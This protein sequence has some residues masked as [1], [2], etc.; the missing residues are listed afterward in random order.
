MRIKCIVSYDGT[1]YSGFQ[2]QPNAVSVQGE[3]EKVLSKMHSVERIQI[4]ASGRTDKGVHARGQVFHF[5]SDLPIQAYA[6]KRAINAQ[7]PKD[8]Y[9]KEVEIVP[10]D[11]HARYNVVAKQYSY[12]VNHDPDED[13]FMRNFEMHYTYRLDFTKMETAMKHFLGAHDFTT[14]C[15]AKNEKVN[16]VRTIYRFDMIRETENRTRF[17]V[18]GDGF[19]YNMVRIMVGTVLD[20]GRGRF[21]P[22]N[23]VHML[24]GKN[25][26]LAGK[27]AAAHGLYLDYVVYD[28]KEK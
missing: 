16:C 18:Y 24:E 15:S 9:I 11:F 14:F 12:L 28:E 23:I 8:I 27:T 25:R 26:K 6:W 7:L 5:D 19:L 4:H 22:D 2:I 1:N 17:V 3:I 20:V 13:V 10:N 21:A